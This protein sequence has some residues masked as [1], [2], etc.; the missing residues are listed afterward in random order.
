MKK[1]FAAAVMIVLLLSAAF[2]LTACNDAQKGDLW[3]EQFAVDASLDAEGNLDVSETWKVGVDSSEGYRNFYK[4]FTL[5]DSNFR[6]SG[7]I[8]NMSV[9]DNDRGLAL[10][11]LDRSYNVADALNQANTWYI[12]VSGSDYEMG[13]IVPSVKS[14][15]RSFTFTYTIT[16]A[17]GMYADTAVLYWK[18]ITEDTGLYIKNYTCVVRLPGNASTQGTRAWFHTEARSNLEIGDTSLLYSASDIPSG[19]Q[20][21]TRIAMP[22]ELFGTLVK[23]SFEA[24][25]ESIIAEEQAWAD[26]WEAK[27][28]AEYRKAVA[29][30]VASSL[31]IALSAGAVL[32]IRIRNRRIKGEYPEYLRDIPKEWSAGELGHLFYYYDGGVEKKNLRGRLLSATVLELARRH[33]IEI[34]PSPEKDYKIHVKD[35]PDTMKGD[36]RPY[37]HTLYRLLARV[38]AWAQHEFTMSEFEK[39]AKKHY[40][41]I[42]DSINEFNTK[43]KNWFNRNAFVGA[44]SRSGRIL[45]AAGAALGV[46]GGVVFMY[47]GAAFLSVAMIIAGIILFVGI[48]KI[49]RLNKKG[50]EE[51]ARANGLK[52]YMLDFSNLKEYEIPQLILW[53]EYLV[54]AT[55]MNISKEV[56]RNLKLVYPE[57]TKNT[58]YER[59]YYNPTGSYLF[60]YLWLS[61]AMRDMGGGFDLGAHLERSITSIRNTAY[62]LQHPSNRPGGGFGGKGF[63]GGGFGGGGFRGGGG[64]FGGGSFGGRH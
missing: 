19:T 17:A 45:S 41:D 63:G 40:A 25:L 24:K 49:P 61:H 7:S 16:D 32:F 36:L 42:D 6:Y 5:Y 13:V 44:L 23:S 52:K 30:T 18:Q 3:M 56:I 21:E 31:L 60:T 53:E 27:Q 64:G 38:E 15:T 39:Y 46:V 9:Y 28:K 26:E 4:T 57:I 50:E 59:G 22:K 47:G 48:P 33:Y 14:G 34:I 8:K 43:S 37:E 55:M 29:N 20:V 1:F 54:Y 10:S 12:R 58:E 62:N 35:V 11:E 2:S 51:L